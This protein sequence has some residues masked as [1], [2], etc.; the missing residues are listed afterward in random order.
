M[1]DM[2]NSIIGPKRPDKA[3]QHLNV[4]IQAASSQEGILDDI[5]NNFASFNSSKGYFDAN[6]K[7]I[8]DT[9]WSRVFTSLTGERLS[10]C[11]N[12]WLYPED[13]YQ[14]KI[15]EV[16]GSNE[17]FHDFTG[18]QPMDVQ[19][20]NI[21]GTWII[22]REKKNLAILADI[23]HEIGHRVYPKSADRFHHELG[24]N[25]F[26]FLAL[27]KADTEMAKF[28]LSLPHIDFGEQITTDHATSLKEARML[29]DTNMNYVHRV[30]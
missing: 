6:N 18:Y 14:L 10:D 20:I 13:Q 5:V 30:T 4:D 29:V 27:K 11:V 26:M 2:T 7:K 1:Y 17:S 15:R 19:G 3:F 25:Y 24:A 28:G 16:F 22:Y 12:I 8:Y 9:L 21:D 23:Y